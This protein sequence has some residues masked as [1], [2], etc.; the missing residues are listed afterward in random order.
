MLDIQLGDLFS[1]IRELDSMLWDYELYGENY[2]HDYDFECTV[3]KV[4]IK[5][6]ASE[7]E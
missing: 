6:I 1:H 7:I 5:R 2:F 3:L 4:A